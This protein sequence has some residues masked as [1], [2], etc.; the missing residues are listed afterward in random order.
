M[1]V[2]HPRQNGSMRE[3]ND[4]GACRNLEGV[5]VTHR[6]DLVSTNAAATGIHVDRSPHYIQV[7]RPPGG[8]KLDGPLAILG[9]DTSAARR[10]IDVITRVPYRDSTAG[11]S[12]V[13]DASTAR[14]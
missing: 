10:Q 11:S 4:I 9:A 14:T 7:D 5:T 12:S 6:F 8:D 1:R 13:A 2:D 3:I